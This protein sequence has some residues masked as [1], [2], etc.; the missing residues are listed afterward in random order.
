MRSRLPT[1]CMI[2]RYCETSQDLLDQ[3]SGEER[4][5]RWP[6]SLLQSGDI[7]SWI[8]HLLWIP[9]TRWCARHKEDH[10]CHDGPVCEPA[11]KWPYPEPPPACPL[12][13]LQL[14]VLM[15]CCGLGHW[16]RVQST[17]VSDHRS[18]TC[19]IHPHLFWSHSNSGVVLWWWWWWWWRDGVGWWGVT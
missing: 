8:H 19:S 13:S 3:Y 1:E 9:Q 15:Y 7:I 14:N 18:I 12:T 11:L 6:H 17:Y 2:L 5:A 10:L 4:A 16:R